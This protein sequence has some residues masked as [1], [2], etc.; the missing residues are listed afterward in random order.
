MAAVTLVWTL[1]VVPIRAD[2]EVLSGDYASHDPVI[3][4]QGDTY[5]VF[6]TGTRI[7]IRSST[8][9]HHWRSVGN[10]L[11]SIP[12]WVYT[13]VPKY[14]GSS[15]W[16]PDIS[17]FNG[18]Y[19][20]YYSVSTF[21]SNVSA[22]GLATNATL[23]PCD[24]EYE[25]V[26]SGGP[27]IRSRASDNYNTIDPALFIDHRD[28]TVNYWLAFG[29]F[30]S[31][32]KMTQIDPATG[33][34]LSSPPVLSSLAWNHSIEAPFLIS[35]NGYYYLFVSFDTCCQGERSTYNVRV[36][37]AADVTGPYTDKD[38]V[39]MMASGGTR[40][41][42][43]DER[44][45][46]PGHQAVFQDQD[47]RYWLVHHAY[48]A[49][50]NGRSYLRIH[51]LFWTPDD[52]PTLAA[53]GPVDVND[54]LV[55]WW[56]LDEGFGGVAADSSGNGYDGNIIGATWIADDPNR[57][58]ALVFDGVDDYIDLPD[59]FSDFNGL[60]ISLWACPTSAREWGG[61]VDLGNGDSDNNIFLG[62][63]RSTLVFG[64]VNG[65][66]NLGTVTAANAIDPG[67]WQH[68]AATADVCGQATLYR[69]G[70]P[71][72]TGTTSP[73]WNVTR[74]DN[75]IARSNWSADAVYQ[76][77]LADVRVYRR[78]LD[79]NDVNDIYLEGD[80]TESE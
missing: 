17:Y 80:T 44:W 12:S 7:P 67:T 41:T 34:P 75:H 21:G 23:D 78:A 53:Q 48:D 38:G 77:L 14:T 55:A 63:S 45:K 42:W 76:G 35:R 37:R 29:S 74:T 46:G 31:G 16:A 60:T 65:T 4:R 50:R 22:I 5:Y 18:K 10:V 79:G 19:H 36:G 40:L 27:I 66:V 28:A 61:F 51:E 24:P 72:K 8:D 30:W 2:Y 1:S 6:C 49:Q 32:I 33:Y 57:G 26:D 11:A 20:L 64:I 73:P 69:N 62:Y 70:L 59:G 52:W 43:S 13:A 15:V 25:W 39:S 58:T 3:M 9:M 68:F 54:A 47:G 71:I 56:N